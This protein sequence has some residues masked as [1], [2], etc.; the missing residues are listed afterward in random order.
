MK[1]PIIEAFRD[2]NGQRFLVI[3]CPD[4]GEVNQFPFGGL[5]PGTTLPCPCGVGFNFSQ[6]SWDDLDQSFGLPKQH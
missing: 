3:T 5:E 1:K 2:P 4:C 6:K